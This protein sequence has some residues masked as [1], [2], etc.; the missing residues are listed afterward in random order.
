MSSITCRIDAALG[1]SED[2]MIKPAPKKKKVLIIGGGPGGMEA[3]RVAALRGHPVVL[4]EKEPKLGGLLPLAALVK[5][6]EIEDL[7][8]LIKY[9]EGQL[10]KLKVDVRLGQEFKLSYLAEIKPDVFILAAGAE[11]TLPDIPGIE[12]KIVVSGASLHQKLKGLL[13]H[14]SPD[15]LRSLTKLWMPVGKR[16]VIIGGGIQGCEL[17]EFMVKRGRNITIVDTAKKLGAGL[18]GIN[19]LAL[20]TWLAKKGATLIPG[21]QKYIEITDKGLVIINKDGQRQASGSR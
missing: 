1:S 3:A 4:Y 17:A 21:V 2:Y 12:N 10:T 8:A 9:L 13:R 7:P 18:A 14:S 15:S 5:G 20:P 19:T 6:T 11:A 16:V